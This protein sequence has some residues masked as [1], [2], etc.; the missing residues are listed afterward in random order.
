[1]FVKANPNP[2]NQRVGDCVIR[3]LCIAMDALQV[4]NPNLYQN[5]MLK[6]GDIT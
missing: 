6:L 1:M 3:A 5:F 4:L 2:C